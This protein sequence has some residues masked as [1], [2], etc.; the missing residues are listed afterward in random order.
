MVVV[1]DDDGLH[2]LGVDVVLHF[3]PSLT[4]QMKQTSKG[5]VDV[6][7]MKQMNRLTHLTKNVEEMMSLPLQLYL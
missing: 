2:D 3:L 1:D 7:Q 6:L 4:G 5:E